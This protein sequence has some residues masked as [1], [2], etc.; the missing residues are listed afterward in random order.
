MKL[1][2]YVV[3]V[4]TNERFAGNPAAV[5]TD[6]S[7]LTET[8]MQS[9]AAEFN[10]SETTFVL[11]VE[12]ST[13]GISARAKV[14]GTPWHVEDAARRN[15]GSEEDVLSVQIRWFTPMNEVDM[16]GHATIAGIHALV[17]SGHIRH[18]DPAVSTPVDVSTRSGTLKTFVENIPNVNGRK[19]LP[20]GGRM[21]WLELIPPTLF[22]I[23]PNLSDLS[24]ILHIQVDAFDSSL[25]P[26]TTQDK[27]FIVFVKDV[28]TLN[29]ARPDFKK[30]SQWMSTHQLR[31]MSL[32]TI[33]TL[34]PAIHVQ[35]RFFAPTVGIDEDPVTGSVH[36]PLA[37][38]LVKHEVVPLYDGLAGLTCVQGVAGGRAGLLHALVHVEKEG[39]FEVRIGGQA[40]TVMKGELYL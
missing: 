6:A 1:E 13:R 4:F 23:A 36:G 28:M 18:D 26:T 16:C 9:I 31:G 39:R 25:S 40:V 27:D 17:E 22:P 32:A 21:I 12:E 3:D 11:P 34:S 33:K 8:Q 30:L 37:A 2:Y 35:S 38:Y 14:G 20:S 24:E 7:G 29:E 19:N 10:L 5:V 15:L